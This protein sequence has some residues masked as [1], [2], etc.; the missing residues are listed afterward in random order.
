MNEIGRGGG[1]RT[2]VQIHLKPTFSA[3]CVSDDS[4]QLT[5][6][7]DLNPF[8]LTSPH[9]IINL[10]FNLAGI[11]SALIARWSDDHLQ[12]TQPLIVEIPSRLRRKPT[13]LQSFIN[14]PRSR[15]VVEETQETP[16]RGWR[17]T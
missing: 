6:F 2:R 16:L 7:D 17:G 5:T 1:D 15:S 13:S 4:E 8:G 11:K 9:D 14:K 12:G 10:R 3:P